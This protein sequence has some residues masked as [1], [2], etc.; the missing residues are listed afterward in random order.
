MPEQPEQAVEQTPDGRRSRNT[1]RVAAS[2]RRWGHQRLADEA[3][4]SKTTIDTYLRE[5]ATGGLEEATI[6]AILKALPELVYGPQGFKVR[7]GAALD[8]NQE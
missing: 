7:E 5:G 8:Y 1:V 2:L 4:I 6:Q 3:G